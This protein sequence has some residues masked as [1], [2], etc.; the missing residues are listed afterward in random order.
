MT[1]QRQRGL[2]FAAV[3][4]CV[5]TA[6][7]ASTELGFDVASVKINQNAEGPSQI[8]GPTPGR[9]VASNTPLRFI[10]L[11][12]YGLL[13]HQLIGAPEWMSSTSIDVTATYPSGTIPTD[14]DVRIMVRHLLKDRFG[15][16]AHN[17]Q[18]EMP[19][20]S[21]TLAR[22]DGRLGPQ[23]KRSDVDCAK[24][25]TADAGGASSLA[26][27]GKRPACGMIATRKFLVGGTRT[28]QQL[29]VTLQGALALG[30]PV[31][32]RTGPTGAYDIDLQWTPDGGD[33][34]PPSIFTALQEQLGLKL[35]PEKDRVEVL[36]IDKVE[37]PA[38]N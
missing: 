35:V 30:R 27:S 14:Q 37:R 17:E 34:D 36:V 23:I 4:F 1:M 38:L 13:D 26:P 15:F 3:I 11:Y 5:V 6:R 8:S 25:P 28:M 29:A 10:V 7:A 16:V 19:I 12:A 22:K 2:T 18:R 21:L 31:F 9:F 33:G 20:Y 32:D 24:R